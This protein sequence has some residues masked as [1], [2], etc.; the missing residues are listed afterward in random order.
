MSDSAFPC[1]E[2]FYR[3][4]IYVFSTKFSQ[5]AVEFRPTIQEFSAA[6]TNFARDYRPGTGFSEIGDP[7]LH[8]IDRSVVTH[9]AGDDEF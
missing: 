2:R 5:Q 4:Y 1:P 7:V 3:P 6:E 9:R 8:A